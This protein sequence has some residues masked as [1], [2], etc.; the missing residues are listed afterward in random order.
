MSTRRKAHKIN[1]DSLNPTP[2]CKYL[3]HSQRQDQELKECKTEE[4]KTERQRSSS[5]SSKR[6]RKLCLYINTGTVRTGKQTGMELCF[7]LVRTG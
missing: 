4:C 7:N 3:L 5:I 6:A 2:K 1:W